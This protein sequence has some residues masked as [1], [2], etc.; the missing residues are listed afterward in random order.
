VQD[1]CIRDG[2]G[3]TWHKTLASAY[4]DK[5]RP[6]RG[7]VYWGDT[8]AHIAIACADDKWVCVARLYVPVAL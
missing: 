2:L 3:D 7:A 4:R 5:K 8:A 6:E 1:E